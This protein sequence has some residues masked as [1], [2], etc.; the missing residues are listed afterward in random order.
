MRS[1]NLKLRFEVIAGIAGMLCMVLVA[2]MLIHVSRFQ[3]EVRFNARGALMSEEI[4]SRV[5]TIQ[6]VAL[7]LGAAVLLV[8]TAVFFGRRYWENARSKF[9]SHPSSEGSWDALTGLPD[10]KQVSERIDRAIELVSGPLESRV[11][12]VAILDIDDFKV[13]NDAYGVS[14]GDAL[15]VS[16]AQQLSRIMRETDFVG[17][18][19]G[20]EFVL[21]F[22]G[23][24][25][26]G[27]I[28]S[29]L[30]RLQERLNQTSFE[31]GVKVSVSIGVS[32]Y[33]TDRQDADHLLRHTDHALYQAKRFGKNMIHFFDPDEAQGQEA[34]KALF[35]RLMQAYQNEEFVLY[36]QPKVNLITGDLVGAEALI[37]WIQPEAGI[38]Q[39]AGFIDIMA[40]TP[41]EI[42]IGKWVIK[43]ALSQAA[44]W[45]REAMTIPVS[46]NISA[47][48]IQ[49][50]GFYEDMVRLLK[51]QPGIDPSLIEIEILESSP[52]DDWSTMINVISAC[53]EL[54]VRFS[55][56]DF[57]TGYSS[58]VQLR[59]LPVDT[60][61]IDQGFTI[62]ML[63]DP[64]DLS[65]IEGI[66][67]L[68]DT[69]S[70]SLV[71]EG[72]ET[73]MHAELLIPIGC[74]LGQGY[75]I[76]R[77]MPPDAL[78][79]WLTHWKSFGF[80]KEIG[81]SFVSRELLR[82]SSVNA[83]HEHWVNQLLAMVNEQDVGKAPEF[84]PRYC[85]FGRWYLGSGK[86]SFSGFPVYAALGDSHELLHEM[87]LEIYQKCLEG[88]FDE[89]L[90]MVDLLMAI[91]DQMMLL[92]SQ[93]R[94]DVKELRAE[95]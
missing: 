91:H 20:D 62:N 56:D 15:L 73:R 67:H 33:P 45:A 35:R 7:W 46:V 85:T 22:S 92:L 76:A 54:G 24:R 59:R 86:R 5:L 55:I 57:G 51:E 65:I 64:D 27:Q 82:L 84:D 14:F 89:A 47:Y 88:H 8:V 80:W 19:G 37:R 77:P 68:S 93:L 50:P 41:L 44:K 9:S 90:K 32:V 3:D 60:L 36:Y 43:T 66:V 17:R 4:L 29:V 81:H 87:G 75:G 38:I 79:D 70:K 53:R 72:V 2:Q 13:I 6:N 63:R 12:V 95:E 42:E 39:P 61:K 21:V 48:Q 49:A 28:Q 74:H 1:P 58:L 23:L 69:F 25:N 71:A 31:N 34:R 52:V 78:Q 16:M 26:R 10:R 83:A 18:L 30:V 94:S 40:K 11:L